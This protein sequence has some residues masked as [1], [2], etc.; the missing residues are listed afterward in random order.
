MKKTGKK[1]QTKDTLLDSL[2]PLPKEHYNRV[3][4]HIRE[5]YRQVVMKMRVMPVKKAEMT[6]DLTVKIWKPIVMALRTDFEKQKQA[7]ELPHNMKFTDYFLQFQRAADRD[8]RKT[9]GPKKAVRSLK[10]KKRRKH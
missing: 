2:G 10:H 8:S 7:R 1:N 3:P 5:G 4:L 9:H 6:F